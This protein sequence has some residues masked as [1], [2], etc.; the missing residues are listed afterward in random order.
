MKNAILGIAF[1]VGYVLAW[2]SA[3]IG[4]VELGKLVLA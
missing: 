3:I 1:L 4:V 2:T